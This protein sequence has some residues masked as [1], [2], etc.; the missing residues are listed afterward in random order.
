MKPSAAILAPALRDAD[1]IFVAL[2]IGVT[3]DLLPEIARVAARRKR[4]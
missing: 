3:L 2:P 4:W 1:L